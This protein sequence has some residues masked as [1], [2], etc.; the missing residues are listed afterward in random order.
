MRQEEVCVLFSIKFRFLESTIRNQTEFKHVLATAVTD[1]LGGDLASVYT[2]QESDTTMCG[3]DTS[4]SNYRR[5]SLSTAPGKV[6]DPVMRRLRQQQKEDQEEQEEE[7]EA[8]ALA[9]ALVLKSA[10]SSSSSSS[11]SSSSS[12][13]SAAAAAEEEKS[14]EI[15]EE[16]DSESKSKSI[17]RRRRLGRWNGGVG[18]PTA[19]PTT[20]PTKYP[21]IAPT[22]A[23]PQITFSVAVIHNVIPGLGQTPE[24]EEQRMTTNLTNAVE[25]DVFYLSLVRAAQQIHYADL[26]DGSFLRDLST[27]TSVDSALAIGDRVWL[28]APTSMPTSSVPTV[29]PTNQPATSFPTVAGD[30]N[31]PTSTPTT[32]VPTT[33]PSSA[34]TTR[35]SSAPSGQPSS[36]PTSPTSMPS[37]EPTVYGVDTSP[38]EDSYYAGVGVGIFFGVVALCGISYCTFHKFSKSSMEKK[39][40]PVSQEMFDEEM[41]TGDDQLDISHALRMTMKNPPGMSTRSKYLWVKPSKPLNMSPFGKNKSTKIFSQAQM[42]LEDGQA[43]KGRFEIED[44]S[45]DEDVDEHRSFRSKIKPLAYGSPDPRVN[46]NMTARMSN[47]VSAK[48]PPSHGQHALSG[49]GDTSS[50]SL[51]MQMGS[52]FGNS[53]SVRL[54]PLYK[55][56]NKRSVIGKQMSMPLHMSMSLGSPGAKVAPGFNPK[57]LSDTI[58]SLAMPSA[59]NMYASGTRSGLEF[60]SSMKVQKKLEQ[61]VLFIKPQLTSES[62]KAITYLVNSQFDDNSVRIIS[63]GGYKGKD[64]GS[65]GLFDHQY[66]DIKVYAEEATGADLGKE[67]SEDELAAFKAISDDV[68][69]LNTQKQNRIFNAKELM[70]AMDMSATEFYEHIWKRRATAHLRIRKGIYIARFD[71]IA[72]EYD[73]DVSSPKVN[74]KLDSNGNGKKELAVAVAVEKKNQKSKESKESKGPVYCINGFYESMRETYINATTINYFVIEWDSNVTRWSDFLSTIVG[75]RDPSLAVSNSIRGTMYAEWERFGLKEP[76]TMRDNGVH[77]SSSALEALKERLMWVRGALLFTDVY[78]SR[79]LGAKIPSSTIKT[80]IDGN[81]VVFPQDINVFDVVYGLNSDECLAKLL[82]IDAK[83]KSMKKEQLRRGLD[84]R[85]RAQGLEK[86]AFYSDEKKT[87]GPLMPNFKVSGQ[88]EELATR[89]GMTAKR[90]STKEV[91]FIMLKPDYSDNPKIINLLRETLN[92]WGVRV[93]SQGKVFGST[94]A[95]A[96]IFEKQYPELIANSETYEPFEIKLS[97]AEN[98][99]FKNHFEKEWPVLLKQKKLLS[100]IAMLEICRVDEEGL[101]QIYLKAKPENTLRIRKGLYVTRLDEIPKKSKRKAPMWVI[102]PFYGSLRSRFE[103]PQTQLNFMVVEFDSANLSWSDFLGDAIGHRDPGKAHISSLRGSIYLEWQKLGLK[104]A[105]SLRDN[106]I[107]ASSS[108]LD[109]LRE[110]LLWVRGSLLFTDLFGARLLASRVQ[111]TAIKKALEAKTPPDGQALVRRQAR[112]RG[113]TECVNLFKES[114]A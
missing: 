13:S 93:L 91:S 39:I 11:P 94:V 106:V 48:S 43:G 95:S 70:S 60:A 87:P 56:Q 90:D 27:S 33:V 46:Q 59:M 2:L 86:G 44:G 78:G 19:V 69:W 107:H 57:T 82:E 49:F 99:T 20:A 111:S 108:A 89:H 3:V 14:S 34:P 9:P 38:I 42:E 32:S 114:I 100:A 72:D 31:A 62:L 22:V 30:T 12:S 15:M 24:G 8:L 103:H 23:P 74:S 63:R 112:G 54:S 45:S 58:D 77:V 16:T 113:S 41:K 109:A 88:V 53:S 26:L 1:I 84:S 51:D 61:A 71:D 21:T 28:N 79:L 36:E 81:P 17:R 7:E 75:D 102:N 10:S 110:R 83:D 29:S 35:P 98:A 25:G 68:P 47:F 52:T 64:V 73:L 50:S 97:V 40:K 92:S 96:R 55:G 6:N 5:L 101:Y 85:A 37:S 67:M 66:A 76:P 4:G 80:W 104:V 18:D 65:M 105:P